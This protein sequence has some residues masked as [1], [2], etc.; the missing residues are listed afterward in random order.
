MVSSHSRH[1]TK[2][3]PHRNDILPTR[4]AERCGKQLQQRPTKSFNVEPICRNKRHCIQ[5][6]R[7]RKLISNGLC[8][9]RRTIPPVPSL[10]PDLTPQFHRT[11]HFLLY[12]P[13]SPLA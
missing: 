13:A 12:T 3:N 6:V 10:N 4:D 7:E 1:L 8:R 11:S 2:S 9:H 5:K